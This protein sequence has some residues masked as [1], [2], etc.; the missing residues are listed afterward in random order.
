M[1]TVLGLDAPTSQAGKH[2][3]EDLDVG[4]VGRAAV[5]N[6]NVVAARNNLQ[7]GGT[8]CHRQIPIKFG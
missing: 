8:R 1:G 2:R 7:S 3:A 6:R 4:W 5:R